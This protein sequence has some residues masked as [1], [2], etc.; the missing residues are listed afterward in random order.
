MRA[1]W[2]KAGERGR[3]ETTATGSKV[4]R[5]SLRGGKAAIH[6]VT[7]FSLFFFSLVG[8]N[9]PPFA[10]QSNKLPS[11]AATVHIYSFF[12]I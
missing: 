10:C 4:T 9:W 11:S 5:K 1:K 8:R 12:C 6:H 7:F 2:R 3:M